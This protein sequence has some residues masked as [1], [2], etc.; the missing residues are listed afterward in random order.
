M[1]GKSL[2]MAVSPDSQTHPLCKLEEMPVASAREVTLP[3]ASGMR[4]L[5]LFRAT[6]GVRAYLNCCPHQGRSLSYAPDQFLFDNDGRL[7][8]PH[9]GA[10]FDLDS[11]HCVS[12]PC[13]GASLTPVATRVENGQVLL[14]EPLTV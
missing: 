7:V 10:C 5:V 6:D 8:C 3:T 12:G 13:L 11:G 4:Y 9:H 14:A 2:H 1:Q